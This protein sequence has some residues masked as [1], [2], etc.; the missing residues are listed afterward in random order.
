MNRR[1]ANQSETA[2]M[3]AVRR[4]DFQQ[5]SNLIDNHGCVADMLRSEEMVIRDG[6]GEI[7]A[8][9]LCNYE[10]FRRL[11]DKRELLSRWSDNRR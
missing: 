4:I 8:I 3:S 7:T 6:D 5:A 1:I 2:N 9:V 11:C 10:E